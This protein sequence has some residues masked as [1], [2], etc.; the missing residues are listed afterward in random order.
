MIKEVLLDVISW[1]CIFTSASDESVRGQC[2][3]R[4]RYLSV[5]MEAALC[6]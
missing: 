4:Q 5:E 1:V 6:P 3:E 2:R